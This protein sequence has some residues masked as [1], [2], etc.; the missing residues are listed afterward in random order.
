MVTLLAGVGRSPLQETLETRPWLDERTGWK[1][2]FSLLP[3]AIPQI[4]I[5]NSNINC[6]I[7][8]VLF[9]NLLDL[10]SFSLVLVFSM[11]DGL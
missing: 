10:S 6:Y 4:L 5:E 7:P 8:K 3:A 2:T 1:A 11:S 9:N